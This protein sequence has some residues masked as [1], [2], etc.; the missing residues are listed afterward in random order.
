MTQPSRRPAVLLNSSAEIHLFFPFFFFFLSPFST[1]TA[2]QFIFLA[3]ER[4]TTLCFFLPRRPLRLSLSD[5]PPFS[6][7][8]LCEILSIRL[9]LSRSSCRGRTA[10]AAPSTASPATAAST[11]TRRCTR[12]WPPR[13]A[14]APPHRPPPTRCPACRPRTRWA[15]G[16]SRG[17]RTPLRSGLSPGACMKVG[18][19]MLFS[20]WQFGRRAAWGRRLTGDTRCVFAVLHER[21]WVLFWGLCLSTLGSALVSD[22]LCQL[23]YQLLSVA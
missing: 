17:N 10:R 20:W 23:K 11:Q 12:P 13:S 7:V 4:A 22:L 16:P 8:R 6:Q 15:T 3:A 14:R 21:K 19:S 18:V 5:R 1:Q 2:P 9:R